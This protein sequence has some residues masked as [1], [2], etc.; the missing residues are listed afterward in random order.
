MRPKH[1][2]Q[3]WRLFPADKPTNWNV[4][5]R[6]GPARLR[7]YQ[8][9]QTGMAGEHAGPEP[10]VRLSHWHGFWSGPMKRPDGSE[11]PITER[12]FDVRWLPP[13]AVNVKDP[14]AAGRGGETRQVAAPRRGSQRLALGF[15]LSDVILKGD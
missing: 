7:A 2:K 12:R 10:H 13:I 3:G 1:T 9:R 6:V 5:V 8:A 15:L 14:R 4:G 11:V